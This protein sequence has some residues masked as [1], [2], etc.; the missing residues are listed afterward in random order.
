MNIQPSVLIWT[1]ICF[2]VF[3]LVISKLLFKPLL[4]IMDARREK[5]ASARERLRE[6]DARLAEA[7]EAKR[8]ALEESKARAA[9]EYASRA[10]ALRAGS[11]SELKAVAAEYE[12]QKE[13]ARAESTEEAAETGKALADAVDTLAGEFA[14]QLLNFR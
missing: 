8:L 4:G 5:T 14:E 7:E 3:M 6:S 1:V 2:C 13:S 12:R 10:E 11:E 9:Q